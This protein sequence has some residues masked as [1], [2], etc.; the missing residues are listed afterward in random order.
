MKFWKAV[1]F[2][3]IFWVIIFFEVSILMFGFKLTSGPGYYII[4]YIFLLIL[5][6]LAVL[7]YFKGRKGKVGEGILF[8]LIMI[9]VGMILD[10]I[11]VVP[12]FIKTYS[13]FLDPMLWIG[14]VITILTCLIAG[15]I[16]K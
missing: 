9:V 10:A 15:L 12:L 1:L 2:G 11:I 8:A 13:F 14:F 5:S 6:V 3:A 7:L 4:H 16:K